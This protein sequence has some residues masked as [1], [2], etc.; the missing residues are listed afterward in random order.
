MENKLSLIDLIEWLFNFSHKNIIHD[1]IVH[2]D[3]ALL[4]K[5]RMRASYGEPSIKWPNR[6]C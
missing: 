3:A 4:V 6:I 1:K 5:N 2:F